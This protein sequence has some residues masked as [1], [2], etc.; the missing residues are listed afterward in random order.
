MT[1]EGG[2]RHK[3]PYGYFYGSESSAEWPRGVSITMVDIVSPA[4]R[5]L[6]LQI[7]PRE[8]SAGLCDAATAL[9]AF[10]PAPGFPAIVGGQ[11]DT[12]SPDPVTVP[13][14]FAAFQGMRVA[15]FVERCSRDPHPASVFEVFRLAAGQL[16]YSR[17]ALTPVSPPAHHAMGRS[18]LA[19]AMTAN[20]PDAW[21]EHY[22]A[23]GYQVCDPVLLR[24]PHQDLPLVWDDLLSRGPLSAKQRRVLVES[25]DA[26]LFNGVS[27][28]LH[29]PRGEIW[30]IS[31]ATEDATAPA[32][33]GLERLQILAIQF[34]ICYSRALRSSSEQFE[35]VRITDRERECLTWTARG[36]SAW[37]IGVILGVS[38][39][40][41][42]FHL[43]RCMGKLG[44]ANR[45]QAVVTALRLG[46]ILP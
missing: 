39:H 32:A 40:T 8:Q 16:G 34:L 4:R 19:P 28:P 3:Y 38:E 23:N 21:I 14:P 22:F 24:T 35:Q 11:V 1:D 30:V 45:M 25:H 13:R 10:L 36:K 44:T 5:R 20:V 46:L 41:V 33:G 18:E 37:S 43:K 15:E 29:G 42:N 17:V 27:I 7:A 31:L 26:G 12:A 6:R 9:S 2:T